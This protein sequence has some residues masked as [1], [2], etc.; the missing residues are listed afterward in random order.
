MSK[1]PRKKP[2]GQ[3]R[4]T[5]G[6]WRSRRLTVPDVASL[7]PSSDRTRETLFNWLGHDLTGLDCADLYAGTGV[8]GLEALSRGAA[9]CVFVESN[10][11]A[12]AALRNS[13]S[14]LVENPDQ[15]QVLQQS[16]DGWLAGQEPSFD[17][18]FAD[19][20]FADGNWAALL[21]GLSSRLRPGARV[22]LE[23]PTDQQ[24]VWPDSFSLLKESRVGEARLRLLGWAGSA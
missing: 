3:I 22:Y 18:V 12:V 1:R 21:A 5:G 15:I 7:R 16:V 24:W 6:R 19:P 2:G 17:L 8:L 14:Q 20:P 10:A 4:I 9:S 23:S 11:I 13:V